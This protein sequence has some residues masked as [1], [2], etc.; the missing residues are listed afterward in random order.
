LWRK[1]FR[2]DGDSSTLEVSTSSR[3]SRGTIIVR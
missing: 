3:F 2:S 1:I